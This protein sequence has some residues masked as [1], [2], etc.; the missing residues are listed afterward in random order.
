MR[1]SNVCID[2]FDVRP[3]CV[4]I[5]CSGVDI[6]RNKSIENSQAKRKPRLTA[7]STEQFRNIYINSLVDGE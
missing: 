3:L 5:T 2:V 1:G 6:Q 7:E 4:D